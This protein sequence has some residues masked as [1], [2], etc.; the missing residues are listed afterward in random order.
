MSG[1]P[2]KPTAIRE[3]EGR[4]RRMAKSYDDRTHEPRPEI[5]AV[6]PPADLSVDARKAWDFLSARLVANRILTE[7]DG[8]LFEAFVRTY[9]LWRQVTRAA[10]KANASGEVDGKMTRLSLQLHTTLRTTGREF[11]LTPA[12]RAAMGARHS[13]FIARSCRVITGIEREFFV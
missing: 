6:D 11:G 4:P 2:R 8:P 13:P 5:V 9:A 10:E 3:L 12:G 7:L 1:P